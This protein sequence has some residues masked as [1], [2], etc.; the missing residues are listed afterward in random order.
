LKELLAPKQKKLEQP[1]Q[2]KMAKTITEGSNRSA[3]TPMLKQFNGNRNTHKAFM[4]L[5]NLFFALEDKHYNTDHKKITFILLLMDKKEA[6]AWRTNFLCK[7]GIAKITYGAYNKFIANLNKTFKHQNEE[8][9]A[10]FN[11]H[12]MKQKRDKSAEQ[13]VT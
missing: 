1:K 8:E 6:R 3:K 9:D 4:D 5:V 11:L 7:N 12:H 2:A 13:A 10:L